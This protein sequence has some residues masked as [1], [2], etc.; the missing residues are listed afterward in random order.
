MAK[1]YSY[2]FEPF[3]LFYKENESLDVEALQQQAH[4]EVLDKQQKV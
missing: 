1:I 3:R 2:M 4:G